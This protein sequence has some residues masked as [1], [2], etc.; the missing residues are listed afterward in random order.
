VEIGNPQVFTAKYLLSAYMGIENILS[1]L[2]IIPEAVVMDEREAVGSAKEFCCFFCFCDAISCCSYA[3]AQ[4]L[5]TIMQ[6][7]TLQVV[8]NES[9]WTYA[10]HG[11]ILDVLPK[12]A[13][14][15]REGDVVARVKNVYGELIH[16]YKAARDGRWCEH[17]C[18]INSR[19]SAHTKFTIN[20]RLSLS[21]QACALARM[22]TLRVASATVSFTS[23][24]LTLTPSPSTSAMGTGSA[25]RRRCATND[26]RRR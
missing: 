25:H 24:T 2:R 8:C 18:D 4:H 22:S 11:G 23:V 14:W 3:R 9:S 1:Y 17:A 19:R 15:V 21:L 12:V 13:A 7:Q 16:V 6:L 10:Q 20:L 5:R 26:K